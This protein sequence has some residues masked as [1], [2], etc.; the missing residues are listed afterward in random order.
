[1]SQDID[2]V[3]ACTFKAADDSVHVVEFCVATAEGKKT[4]RTFKHAG[5]GAVRISRRKNSNLQ[6]RQAGWN[7]AALRRDTGA[8]GHGDDE[9]YQKRSQKT[10]TG[11]RKLVRA[12]QDALGDEVQ[13]YDNFEVDGSVSYID[14]DAASCVIVFSQ[15][16]RRFSQQDRCVGNVE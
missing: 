7:N 11:N 14:R 8:K 16:R 13:K 6:K 10:F 5:V 9:K 12:T 3:E 1:M 4:I 15:V 2:I